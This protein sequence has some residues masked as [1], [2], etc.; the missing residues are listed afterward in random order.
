MALPARRMK[1][2]RRAL[3][4]TKSAVK[5]TAGACEACAQADTGEPDGTCA[6]VLSGADP[7]DDCDTAPAESCGEDG[8]CDGARACRKYGPNQVCADSICSGSGHT[9]VRMCDGAG[10]CQAAA[11][12]DCG[13]FPCGPTGCE[14]PCTDHSSCPDGG[15]CDVDT[16][17]VKKPDGQQCLETIECRSGSCR[18]GVCCNQACSLAC[19]ACSNATTGL[20][21]GTCGARTASTTQPCPTGNPTTCVDLNTDER[22]CGSCNSP[23]GAQAMCVSGSCRAPDAQPCSVDSNCIS[24]DCNTFYR[25]E[26]GDGYGAASSGSGRF[27]GADPPNS[28]WSGQNRDCCDSNAAVNPGYNGGPRVDA[29]A[30]CAPRPYDWNCDGEE[31]R[32]YSTN[33]PCASYTTSASCPGSIPSAADVLPPCGTVDAPGTACGWTGSECVNARGAVV[34]QTCQ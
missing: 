16:C 12:T 17:R 30:D 20:S 1:S 10:T 22:N 2:A 18:D 25:D 19:Q 7:H 33:A 34:T 6:P 14:Q 31:T 28:D 26:D 13:E 29:A 5:R 11:A 15:F 24:N 9:P 27:C 21:N 4:G 32:K 23:C 3:V 8:T